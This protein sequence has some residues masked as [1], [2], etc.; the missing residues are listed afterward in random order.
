MANETCQTRGYLLGLLVLSVGLAVAKIDYNELQEIP[1]GLLVLDNG[2][3]RAQVATWTVLVS[4]D[5]PHYPTHFR[6]R[7]TNVKIL[8]ET[9][10]KTRIINQ[11]VE[12]RW[13]QRINALRAD[14]LPRR[15]RTRHR[16]GLIN[17]IG[18][19]LSFLFGTATT[20]QV[21]ECQQHV[22]A[23]E[24]KAKH[25]LHAT[26]QLVSIVNHSRHELKTQRAHIE[27]IESYLNTL[28]EAVQQTF[29]NISDL[30]EQVQQLW[31]Y[32]E[33][34]SYLGALESTH[35]AWQKQMERYARE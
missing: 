16:R 18:K 30:E 27:K 5:E 10:K 34:D 28:A 15:S 12:Q 21:R 20:D 29:F 17:G 31:R 9:L 32:R 24:E 6:T 2:A 19:G 7:L 14:V 33:I 4:L 11:E 22:R 1:D 35:H 3:V 26:N 13:R 8:L 25:V 23:A